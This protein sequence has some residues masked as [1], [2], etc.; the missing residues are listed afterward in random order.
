MDDKQRKRT[1]EAALFIAP[2]AMAVKDLARLVS[3]NIA[4]TRVL[5]N[6][7]MHA[8]DERETALGIFAE[9]NGFRMG[10]KRKYEDEVS[11][12]ASAPEF[13]KGVMKT[14]AY[15]AYKQPVP[16]S[17]VIKFRNTKAYDHVKMLKDRG[18]ITKIPKG[19]TYTI[20]TTKK[21]LQYFGKEMAARGKPLAAPG[22]EAGE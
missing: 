2:G 14:L 22:A 6:E 19:P 8:Y 12:L 16:Q 10:V 21:F 5:V 11:H 9:E 4:E 3:L 15:I 20:R 17:D 18:F 7:L 13:H 1:I